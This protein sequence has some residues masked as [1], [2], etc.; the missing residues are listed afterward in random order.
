VHDGDTVTLLT[1][2]KRTVKIRLTEIDAPELKQLMPYA[3]L[4]KKM[5]CEN[6]HS[7]NLFTRLELI[8]T[9]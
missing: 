3:G 6:T 5:D 4:L 2:N 9:S 7:A 1:P 8:L